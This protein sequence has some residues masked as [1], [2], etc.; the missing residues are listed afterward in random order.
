MPSER[1]G[2]MAQRGDDQAQRATRS[3]GIEGIARYEREERHVGGER[4]ASRAAVDDAYLDD[5][6]LRARAV[7]ALYTQPIS[8]LRFA[9]QGEMR[10]AMT[11][12]DA[13]APLTRQHT[14]HVVRRSECEIAAACAV[15]HRDRPRRSVDEGETGDRPRVGPRPW[16]RVPRARLHALPCL[17][18]EPLREGCFRVNPARLRDEEEARRNAGESAEPQRTA[19]G[20]RSH[21]IP[22][23]KAAASNAII[24]MRA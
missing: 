9:E 15:Q 5:G 21:D 11:R 20:V 13:V 23:S 12:D 4:D 3:H 7:L 14:R 2:I 6:E 24:P 17:R 19:A 1:R 8:C 22:A 18:D 10:I 16:L